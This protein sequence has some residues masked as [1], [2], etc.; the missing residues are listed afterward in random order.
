MREDND[1]TV[2][3]FYLRGEGTDNNGDYV[4]LRFTY[5]AGG[6]EEVYYMVIKLIPDY[7]VTINGTQ[8]ATSGTTTDTPASNEGSM[9]VFTP[10]GKDVEDPAILN[11]ATAQDS[12]VD[13]RSPY[14]TD[15]TLSGNRAT[16]LTYKLTVLADGN[17]YNTV[18]N[19]GKLN[20][21]NPVWNGFDSNIK[22]GET[23]TA[24][25][26]G[27]DLKLIPSA[28]IF[29]SKTYMLEITNVYGFT[30]H[31]YFVLTTATQQNPTIHSS[32]DTNYTEGEGFDV[33]VIYDLVSIT[34]TAEGSG[35]YN[36]AVSYD[37]VPSESSNNAIIIDNVDTWGISTGEY[38]NISIKDK[39]ASGDS[40]YGTYLEG[41]TKNMTYQ[42]VKVTGISF[43]YG[44]E[45]PISQAKNV[46]EGGMLLA[47]AADGIYSYGGKTTSYRG[48][49]ENL[50]SRPFTVPTLP[51]WYYGTGDSVSVTVRVTLQYSKGGD[52]ETCEVSFTATIN[53]QV[54]IS[55]TGQY[56]VDGTEFEID[57]YITASGGDASTTPTFYDDTLALTISSGGQVQVNVT[58]NGT[59]YSESFNNTRSNSSYTHYVSLSDVVGRTL[60]PSSDTVTITLTD[61][62]G[63]I[64]ARYAGSD[65]SDDAR[66]DGYTIAWGNGIAQDALFLEDSE[67]IT[68][69]EHYEISKS[70]IVGVKVDGETYYYRYNKTY[71]I[72]S[73]YSFLNTGLGQSDLKNIDADANGNNKLITGGTLTPGSTGNYKIPIGV[74]SSGVKVGKVG[75]P[76]AFESGNM[77]DFATAV[78]DGSIY[79]VVSDSAGALATAYFDGTYL[80]TG[81]GYTIGS[82]Q[83]IQIY[84]YVKAAGPKGGF[85]NQSS[86]GYDKLL[87]GYR[88]R[89][90]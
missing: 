7:N 61:A 24:T 43:Q 79:F 67:R 14:F 10:T 35:K 76:T 19:I 38:E 39:V 29:G 62:V 50:A 85:A 15:P 60:D 33:G 78:K 40:E 69:S 48:I 57:E 41:W 30:V 31:Y 70:Y 18:S 4:L 53:K 72:T 71:R 47:T 27:S 12:V 81:A 34:E 58:L 6:E 26:N 22:A 17:G 21:S 1:V 42:Y 73:D 68:N 23:Y 63:D 51:G 25:P 54:S 59:T 8:V 28:V 82:D 9:H 11:I 65:I 74:W 32:T 77:I 13:F 86:H 16:S 88:I 44:D 64:I 49:D 2:Y 20:L 80:Y 87:G 3:D 84:I 45:E 46:A 5:S 36:V 89:L 52:T 90:I 37:N 83:Y 56:V 75:S 66:A 55:S